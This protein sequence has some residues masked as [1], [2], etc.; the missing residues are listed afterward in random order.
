MDS[1]LNVSFRKLQ[2]LSSQN[3]SCYLLNR[4]TWVSSSSCRRSCRYHHLVVSRFTFFSLHNLHLLVVSVV[5]KAKSKQK[6]NGE[7]HQC[8]EEISIRQQTSGYFYLFQPPTNKSIR[9][10]AGFGCRW[11]F[12]HELE[13]N[14]Y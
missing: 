1:C 14:M 5:V 11:F 3:L 8:I 9:K 2:I 4:L 12:V 10:E 13:V 6:S 7:Q